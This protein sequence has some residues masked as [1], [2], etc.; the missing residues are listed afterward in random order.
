MTINNTKC[1]A[2]FFFNHLLLGVDT[3]PNPA[4]SRK[5]TIQPDL[6]KF[7]ICCISQL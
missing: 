5:S 2:I 1:H 6:Q 3:D 4:G 7:L